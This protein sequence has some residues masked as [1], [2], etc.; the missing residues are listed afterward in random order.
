MAG[1]LADQGVTLGVTP[2][3]GQSAGQAAGRTSPPAALHPEPDYLAHLAAGRFMLLRS[4]GSG[5]C[6]FYP[7][8]A[9]PVS[10]ARDLDW[11]PASGLGTVHA[12]T[13]VRPRPPQPAYNV[14]LITLA[15]GPRLMSRVEG[16]AP[17]LVQIG[18]AVRAR[19]GQQDGQPILL[20][21]PAPGA[22]AAP[23]TS[24]PSSAQQAQP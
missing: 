4:R 10:G 19:I 16:L 23:D 1:P 9:E 18:L 22:P 21:E 8:L 20:F 24:T 13:V 11:V 15:E 12:T 5:R 14:A 2:G 3:G 17:E 7:R 6:F